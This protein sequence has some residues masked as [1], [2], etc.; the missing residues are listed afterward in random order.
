MSADPQVILIVA[1]RREDRRALFDALDGQGYGAILCARDITHARNL[2]AESPAPRLAVL[3]FC[4]MPAESAAFGAELEG[5]P[6]IGLLGASR[7]H[8]EESVAWDFQRRPP[9]VVEW[10]RAPVDA[11]EARVRAEAVLGAGA[12][13]DGG[14][15]PPQ[16]DYR[17]SFE[18]S[19]DGLLFSD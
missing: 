10:L 15:R 11:Q 5:V 2:L 12:T 14:G 17:C 4:T 7:E 8:G 3:D 9:G 1:A 18:G 13:P 6:V 16:D 19:A